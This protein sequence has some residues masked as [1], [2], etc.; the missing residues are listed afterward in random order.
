MEIYY[1]LPSPPPKKKKE[2]GG[3]KEK[4]KKKKIFPPP[5]PPPKKKKTPHKKNN[6]ATL[7]RSFPLSHV[8]FRLRHGLI[9]QILSRDR[10]GLNMR[11]F[12]PCLGS[13]LLLANVSFLASF[14]D[15]SVVTGWFTGNGEDG[16]LTMTGY[17]LGMGTD[18]REKTW[19]FSNW[20]KLE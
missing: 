16:L 19:E 11:N 5:P 4:K 8:H 3:G 18:S 15:L 9:G 1:S 10:I 6:P 14:G 7:P 2:G 20:K 17:F 12:L 13:L